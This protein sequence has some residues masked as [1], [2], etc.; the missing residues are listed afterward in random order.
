[1]TDFFQSV[2]VAILTVLLLVVVAGGLLLLHHNIQKYTEVWLTMATLTTSNV[3]HERRDM[4]RSAVP[5][6]LISNFKMVT[7][8]L[9]ALL[10]V[11]GTYKP[12]STHAPTHT[13]ARAEEHTQSHTRAHECMQPPAQVVTLFVCPA[14]LVDLTNMAQATCDPPRPSHS[15]AM[16]LGAKEE[17]R[18]N[19]WLRRGAASSLHDVARQ[20]FDGST[21]C[22]GKLHGRTSLR[23]EVPA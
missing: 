9:V 21:D 12:A 4:C 8:A 13:H 16:S 6:E 19:R 10:T 17:S 1:M 18:A 14:T 20:G 23:N 11:I 2:I 5:R 3:H 7:M 22:F 15:P